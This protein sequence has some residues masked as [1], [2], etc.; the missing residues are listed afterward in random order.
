[1]GKSI[2]AQQSACSSSP[3][4]TQIEEHARDAAADTY[5]PLY[6]IAAA[7]GGLNRHRVAALTVSKKNVSKTKKNEKKVWSGVRMSKN[8]ALGHCL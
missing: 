8:R 3:S 2:G 5:V 4:F 1:M 6:K 7:E